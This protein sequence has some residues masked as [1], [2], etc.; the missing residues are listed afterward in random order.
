RPD[1][2]DDVPLQRTRQQIASGVLFWIIAG[3]AAR[4][5]REL[6][7]AVAQRRARRK[8][9]DHVNEPRLAVAHARFGILADWRVHVRI[10]LERDAPGDAGDGV[11]L[12]AVHE[13][14]ADRRAAAAQA[15]LPPFLADY[16][17]R[18]RAEAIS[19]R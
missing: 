18:P 4:D 6:R 1:V 12:A 7:I 19:L 15:P 5:H 11:R 8:P 16:R 14:P 10:A 2:G 13:L 17:H 9:R 3:E